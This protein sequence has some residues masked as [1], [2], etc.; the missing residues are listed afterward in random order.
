MLRRTEGSGKWLATALALKTKARPTKYKKARYA[1]GN[2]SMKDLSNKIKE[3]EKFV[4]VP[5]LEKTPKHEPTLSYFHLV[6]CLRKCMMRSGE[7]NHHVHDG[8]KKEMAPSSDVKNTDKDKDEDESNNP[9][10][11]YFDEPS[12]NVKEAIYLTY[13]SAEGIFWTNLTSLISV[14]SQ[15]PRKCL[16]KHVLRHVILLNK[17]NHH[18]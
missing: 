5:H 10:A 3:F 4:K 16:G 11:R 13:L 7:N 14:H 18:Q 17:R 9:I 2:V 15:H 8:Y 6:E 1:I 12:A